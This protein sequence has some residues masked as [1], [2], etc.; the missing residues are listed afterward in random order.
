MDASE[1]PYR[2]HM[3]TVRMW[4]EGLEAS[5]TEWRGQAQ[6]VGDGEWRAFREWPALIAFFETKLENIED[7]SGAG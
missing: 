7:D 6:F 4:R 3:F 1:Q 2:R 5:Q